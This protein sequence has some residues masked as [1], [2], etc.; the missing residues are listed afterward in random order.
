MWFVV[1]FRSGDSPTRSHYP[2]AVRTQD[3]WDDYGYETT[4]HITLHISAG[5]SYDLVSDESD[6]VSYL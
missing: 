1:R 2:D 3:N 6:T 4:F 5:D